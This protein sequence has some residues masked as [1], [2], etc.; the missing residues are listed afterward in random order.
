M[1]L[2][3]FREH[4]FFSVNKHLLSPCYISGPVLGQVNKVNKFPKHL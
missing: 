3:N 4:D 2:L 1:Y